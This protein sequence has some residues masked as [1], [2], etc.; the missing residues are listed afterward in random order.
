[1]I[2]TIKYTIDNTVIREREDGT[3]DS[4]TTTE[5]KTETRAV[6]LSRQG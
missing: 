5:E 3:V 2:L 4:T 1:M 6:T